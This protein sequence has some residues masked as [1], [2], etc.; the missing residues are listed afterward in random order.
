MSK[1]SNAKRSVDAYRDF[2]KFLTDNSKAAGVDV[3]WSKSETNLK[4][5]ERMENGMGMTTADIQSFMANQISAQKQMDFQER[6]SNTQW[7]RGVADMQAAGLNPALAYSQGGSAAPSG[8]SAQSDATVTGRGAMFSF[9]SQMAS[10]VKE[11][12]SIP[13]DIKKTKAETSNLEAQNA[14][15]LKQNELITS[16]IN[17]NNV[18]T[19]GK[20]IENEFA[21]E[22]Y[23]LRKQGVELANNLTEEQKEK[24]HKEGQKIDEEIGFIKQQAATEFEKTILTKWQVAYQYM[25]VYEK[26]ALLPLQQQ[27]LRAQTWKEQ[28]SAALAI[29]NEAK[30]RHLLNIGFYDKQLELVSEQVKKAGSDAEQ[31]AA[32]AAI[33]AIRRSMRDG[34]YFDVPEIENFGQAVK[35]GPEYLV[36]NFL[37]SIIQTAS[38]LS[39]ISL[40]AIG[41]ILK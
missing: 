13:F 22:T 27:L 5:T 15:L 29:V 21:A 23:Q 6:M 39:D 16:E 34:T 10:L 3:D 12:V 37:N 40:G 20:R 30:E 7:Q 9:L 36:T 26:A 32:Q 41:N 24:V 4:N 2:L 17:K 25:S 1:K 28:A 8:A 18:D 31:A 19:Q 33:A 35:Y 38:M 14:N 11:V